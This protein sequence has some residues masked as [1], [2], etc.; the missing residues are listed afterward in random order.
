ML[1]EFM[2]IVGL[3]LVHLFAARIHYQKLLPH[4]AWL[5]F[6]GGVSVAYVF[7]YIF[8]GLHQ[9]HQAFS[10]HG[11]LLWI[12][13][14][15][16]VV[17]LIGLSAF[18]G[19]ERLA[20]RHSQPSQHQEESRAPTATEAGVFWLH[21]GSFGLYNSLIG[22]LLAY[23]ETLFPELLFFYLAMGFHFLVNDYGLVQHHRKVYLDK[24]R[25]VLTA[26]VL[27][28]WGVGLTQELNEQV[29]AALYAF[30]AGGL[31]LNVL[32]EELP[33][34]RQGRFWYFASGAAVTTALLI[35]A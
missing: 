31:I 29:I 35:M 4:R 10:D 15:A 24:G 33:E 34:E 28:G 7:V 18:Y 17:A 32:K 9:A 26:A 25:W 5:S 6:A 1:L 8:P 30:V 19:L 12:E 23:Q 27:A 22:Y 21:I 2:F 11:A 14:N 3:S 20:K 16:Y 13:Y